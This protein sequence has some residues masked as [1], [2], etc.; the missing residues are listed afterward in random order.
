MA[1]YSELELRY[2]RPV[3]EAVLA[4]PAFRR[5]LL[6]Q[7][8]FERT[9]FDAVPIGD[10]QA[11]LRSRGLKNPYWFN[12]WCGKDRRCSCRVGTGIETDILII[13]ASPQARR[14]AIHIEVKRPGEKLGDGQAESY[15]RRAA[16]WAS[17]ETRPRTVP[18][19]DEFITVL[20]AGRSLAD[21]PLISLFDKVVF[22]DEVA[23]LIRPFP[24]P[25]PAN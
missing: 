5:W 8:P 20:L 4:D 15:R 13:L 10:E 9:Y 21:D 18:P 17:V 16:C 23:G 22:H 19:H 2:A 25:A 3:A 14:L 1:A 7:T 12:Y 11:R 6:C 24:E